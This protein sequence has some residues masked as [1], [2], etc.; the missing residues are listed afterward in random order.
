M[1]GESVISSR[2]QPWPRKKGMVPEELVRLLAHN[3]RYP[4][5]L[6]AIVKRLRFKTRFLGR[7][8]SLV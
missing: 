7:R 6:K 8:M 3:H 4:G 1:K 2:S 5:T